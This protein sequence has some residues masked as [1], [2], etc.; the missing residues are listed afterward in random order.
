MITDDR[1]REIAASEYGPNRQ[2][3][4]AMARELL[5]LRAA[6][7]ALE[8]YIDDV[9]VESHFPYVSSAIA[10][11]VAVVSPQPA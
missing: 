2:E 7:R 6:V 11:A 3:G 4:A 5:A 9:S 1:L 8:P 10:R